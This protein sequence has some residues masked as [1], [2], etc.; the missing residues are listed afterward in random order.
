MKK[1]KAVNKKGFTLME[2]LIVVVIIGLL[3]AIAVPMYKKA[4][5]KSKA[6]EALTTM[7]AVAKSEHDWYLVKNNYTKDFAELDIDLIDK[8]GNKAQDESY[9]GANYTYTLQ[10]YLIKATRNNNEYSL[11]KFYEMGDI[12][13]LPQ[14]HYICQLNMWK[15]PNSVSESKCSSMNGVWHNSSSSC[16]NSAKERCFTE[17]GSDFWIENEND[18][19]KDYCGKTGTF[20]GKLEEGMKCYGS[21]ACR[22]VEIYSGAECIDDANWVY[23]CM[24]ATIYPGGKCTVT[25]NRSSYGCSGSTIYG[26]C[27]S[28]GSIVSN[29]KGG[30]YNST[31]K[32]GGVCIGRGY[33]A[34]GSNTFESG[35]TCIAYHSQACNISATN[36][37]DPNST[38]QPGS[39]CQGEVSGG[40]GGL[41]NMQGTC[42]V[43]GACSNN[44]YSGNGCCKGTFCPTKDDDPNVV[45]CEN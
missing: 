36:S 24:N 10:D 17:Y 5:E 28:V 42:I 4:V 30:C 32:D 16:Y 21:G 9:E 25:A 22:D 34:C 27:D 23:T 26:T 19:S 11:Y 29:N 20:P 41:E 7:Q 33:T 31:V 1:Q 44:T 14:E 38:Y 45:L 12:Y 39:F 37:G 43:A 3:S 6:S 18:H 13:C 8:E 35:S 40:C 2:L 15:S